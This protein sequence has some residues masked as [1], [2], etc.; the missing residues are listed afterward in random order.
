M[1]KFISTPTLSIILSALA[2]AFSSSA[3]AKADGTRE[4][5]LLAAPGFDYHASYSYDGK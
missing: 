2:L 3:M 5:K 4:H 1:L